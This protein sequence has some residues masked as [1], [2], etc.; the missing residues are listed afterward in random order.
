M[1]LNGNGKY[2][3][4]QPDS[5]RE[6]VRQ[7]QKDISDIKNMLSTHVTETKIHHEYTR[8]ELKSIKRKSEK[9]DN[10]RWIERTI[11]TAIA[12]AAGFLASIIGKS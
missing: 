7:Q 12:G 2:D 11:N 1:N 9:D 8:E 5:L 10:R 6:V 3:H 4:E